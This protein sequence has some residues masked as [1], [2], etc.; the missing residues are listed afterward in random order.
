MKSYNQFEEYENNDDQKECPNCS[1]VL[2]NNPNRCPYCLAYL[3]K[4]SPSLNEWIEGQKKLSKRMVKCVLPQQFERID[5]DYPEGM[6]NKN[7]KLIWGQAS[8]EFPNSKEK[9]IIILPIPTL[10]N[11]RE[12]LDTTAHES[13]HVSDKVKFQQITEYLTK[14]E[15]PDAHDNNSDIRYDYSKGF[16]GR[17]KAKFVNWLNSLNTIWVKEY[18]NFAGKLQGKYGEE[19]KNRFKEYRKITSRNYD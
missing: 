16:F 14:G 7:N 6:R 10:R 9:S 12:F 13:A 15:F 11:E 1:Y 8:Y 4:S 19:V 3:I 2:R 17:P 5:F 18:F